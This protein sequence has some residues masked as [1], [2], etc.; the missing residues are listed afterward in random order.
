MVI[1]AI[2]AEFRTSKLLLDSI[3]DL[4]S[5]SP[6]ERR[7]HHL[8]TS[9]HYSLSILIRGSEPDLG[10]W[11]VRSVELKSVRRSKKYIYPP[12][13]AYTEGFIEDIS[14]SPCVQTKDLNPTKLYHVMKYCRG[15]SLKMAG[16]TFRVVIIS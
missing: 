11:T 14:S 10:A 3:L 6:V 15:H 2:S 7:T 8:T 16:K 9:D 12:F 4:V 13:S 5:V 1:D